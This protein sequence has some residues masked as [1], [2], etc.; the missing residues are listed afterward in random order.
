MPN[1]NYAAECSPSKLEKQLV[2]I[3]VCFEA[4]WRN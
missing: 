3:S 2:E 4:H 1:Q